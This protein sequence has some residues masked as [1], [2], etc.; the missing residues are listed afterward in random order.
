MNHIKLS[1][2]LHPNDD[3]SLTSM[4]T[5][6]GTFRAD[7]S[8]ICEWTETERQLMR[9]A[10]G[11]I[12]RDIQMV[13]QVI[14]FSTKTNPNK[15]TPTCVQEDCSQQ[16][17]EVLVERISCKFGPF[18]I[19]LPFLRLTPETQNNF[20]HC[21]KRTLFWLLAAFG[22]IHVCVWL[23]FCTRGH[24]WLLTSS[25]RPAALG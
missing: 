10:T 22:K 17:S 3:C 18:V 20:L 21:P 19:K 12:L 4:S 2:T 15:G 5:G 1:K 7:Q 9:K 13:C 24:V 23:P 6:S 8:E 25:D 14:T 16:N 11:M